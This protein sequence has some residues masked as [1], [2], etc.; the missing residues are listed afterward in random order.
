MMVPAA[1]PGVPR[2]ALPAHV[3]QGIRALSRNPFFQP[4]FS[5]AAG[6]PPRVAGRY[7][8]RTPTLAG[9]PSSPRR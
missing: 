7:A 1:R 6:A 3:L 9:N 2:A 8:H 4:G 5:A